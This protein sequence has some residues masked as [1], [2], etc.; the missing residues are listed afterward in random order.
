MRNNRGGSLFC[1]LPPAPLA[2]I[3]G[4]RILPQKGEEQ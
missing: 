4:V 3:L 2:V 1:F